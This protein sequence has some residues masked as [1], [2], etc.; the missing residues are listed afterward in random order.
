MIFQIDKEKM[1]IL[2]DHI[3]YYNDDQDK[4]FLKIKMSKTHNNILSYSNKNNH[5][6]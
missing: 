1:E 3:P 4:T 2:K 5:G 6:K